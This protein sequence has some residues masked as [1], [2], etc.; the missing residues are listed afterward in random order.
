VQTRD[1]PRKL[2]T[3]CAF[4]TFICVISFFG[5]QEW[6]ASANL[7]VQHQ[8]APYMANPPA[9][10]AAAEKEKP[11]EALARYTLWLMIFTAVLAAATVGLG[12]AT[13]GLYFTGE[14]QI[15]IARESADAARLNA[16]A[17]ISAERAHLITIIVDTNIW[18]TLRSSRFYGESSSPEMN[19][20][21]LPVPSFR[22]AI[23]N[24]GRTAAVLTEVSYQLQ[25][26]AANRRVWE[27]PVFD[28][29]V[30]PLIEG[31][32]TSDPPTFCT[33]ASRMSLRDGVA[34]ID[35]RRPLSFY[36]YVDFRDLFRREYR[37]FWRYEFR[38]NRFVLVYEEEQQKQM[39]AT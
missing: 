33:I 8:R 24:T 29:I 32:Q 11:E 31:A 3:A 28:T 38:D 4:L 18:E 17:L 23:R 35:G 37:Y 36:G 6:I 10:H 25:Q 22:F 26:S 21:E 1:V 15:G 2:A 14:K 12:A 19:D 16:E 20:S 13:V 9:E 7:A 39:S 27:Y 5:Y 30:S 34:A